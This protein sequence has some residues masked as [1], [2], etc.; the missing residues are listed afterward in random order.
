MPMGAAISVADGGSIS[1][2]KCLAVW[3]PYSV[4]VLAEQE[5]VVSFHDFVENVSVKKEVDEA[6][7]LRGTVVL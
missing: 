3:D 2:G 7:G 6:T 4:P 1:A 5:G